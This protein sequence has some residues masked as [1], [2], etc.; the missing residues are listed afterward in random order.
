VVSHPDDAEFASIRSELARLFIA[1]RLDF[2]LA[3]ASDEWIVAHTNDLT[4][5]LWFL[6][7]HAI[8]HG[9]EA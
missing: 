1:H 2:C 7:Q 5:T 4:A 8:V 6:S 9:D 3:L